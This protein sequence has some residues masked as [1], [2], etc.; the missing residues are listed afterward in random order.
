MNVG[1]ARPGDPGRS[2]SRMGRDRTASPAI[3]LMCS[4]VTSPCWRWCRRVFSFIGACVVGVIVPNAGLV[5]APLFNGLFGAI[6]GYV[7]S[8][9]MVLVLG[10]L[11][12][13][14]GAA[15]RRPPR[16]RQ[17]VQ[18]CGLFLHAGLARRHFPGA[19]GLAL[20]HAHR[21]LRRV[22][23]VARPAATDQI[24]RAKIS[25]LR[26]LD[27]RLRLRARSTSPPW[28]NASCSARRVCERAKAP[29]RSVCTPSASRRASAP[30][31]ASPVLSAASDAASIP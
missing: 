27:C 3:R 4:A 15:V 22:Y 25:R 19:A 30:V 26:R 21:L 9:A 18:A 20:S 8:C 14:V 7:L 10:I 5:R 12:N 11:I 23:S 31:S 13:L 17:R 16:F 6:F 24:A 2:G 1:A 29:S 28:R